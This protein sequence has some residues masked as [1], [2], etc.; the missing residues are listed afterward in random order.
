MEPSLAGKVALVAGAT[1]GA[2]RGIAVQLGAAGA[3]VYVTGRTTRAQRSEMNRP[4]TIEETAALVDEAGG[5]GVAVQVDHLVPEQVRALTARIEADEGRLDVLVNDIW[6]ATVMEWNRTVVGVLAGGGPAHPAPGRGDARDHQPFRAAA[7]DQA[8]GRAGGRGD[9]RDRCLQRDQLSGVVLLRPG[10]GGGEPDG[11]CAGARAAAPW[12]HGGGADAGL[13]AVGGDARRLWRHGGELAR[14]DPAAAA[15]RDLGDPRIRGS[16]RGGAGARSRRCALERPVAVQRAAGAGLR[17]HRSRRQPTRCLAVPGRGP[18]CRR[19]GGRDGVSLGPGTSPERTG[20][21]NGEKMRSGR[22][23]GHLGA[24]AVAAQL[25]DEL[26]A[27]GSLDA[28][29]LAERRAEP[30]AAAEDVVGEADHAR[31][32]PG[33]GADLADAGEDAF[34]LAQ[35]RVAGEQGRHGGGRARDAGVAVDQEVAEVLAGPVQLPAELDQL[36]D[37]VALGRL[38]AGPGADDVV[39]AHGQP[40]VRIVGGEGTRFGIV[41]VEDREDVGH[42][43]A[44]VRIELVQAADGQ[45]EPGLEQGGQH[46]GFLVGVRRRRPGRARA[47]RRASPGPPGSRSSRRRRPSGGSP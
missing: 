8:A 39:E 21:Q 17:L 12:R 29:V 10:E 11:V 31:V 3:T 34:L 38:P 28:V 26:G 30:A 4:E 18:G 47:C 25:L 13:A 15:L 14:R 23:L 2:G 19:A 32:G 5:R 1:R 16:G 24:A 9:G 20:W 40:V 37:M 35:R 22:L 43:G 46:L 42:L 41:G 45:A 33:D 44:A 6:G 27:L 7:A 36:L